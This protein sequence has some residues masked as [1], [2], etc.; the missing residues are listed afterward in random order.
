V[1]VRQRI[2]AMKT[3]VLVMDLDGLADNSRKA[4]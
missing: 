4:L 3:N 2:D 1:A